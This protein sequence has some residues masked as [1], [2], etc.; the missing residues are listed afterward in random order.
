VARGLR[1]Y[2][3]AVATGGLPGL[4]VGDVRSTAAV[5]VS[6]GIS[7]MPGDRQARVTKSRD[8]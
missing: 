4:V 8:A 2:R 3:L 6:R 5:N 7:Q 1:S